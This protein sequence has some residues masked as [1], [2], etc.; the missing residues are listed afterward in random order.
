[1][2]CI[3]ADLARPPFQE[4]AFDVVTSQFG[5][6]YAGVE[7]ITETAHLVAPGGIFAAVLHLRDGGIFR[8]CTI[9]LEAIDGFRDCGL[10][11]CFEE[12]Y[13]TALAVHQRRAE[14][15]D[16]ERA[17]RRFAEAV[18]AAED[19]LRRRGRGVATGTLYRI[20]CDIGHMYQRLG[21]YEPQ[22]L[23]EWIDVTAR[24]LDA[25]SGRMSSMLGAALDARQMKRVL[26]DLEKLGLGV[27]VR[28]ILKFGRRPVPCAWVIVAENPGRRGGEK[29]LSVAQFGTRV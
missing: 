20:Y 9:N 26:A 3:A 12:V 2:F 27:R 22:E 13:R 25:Y 21:A 17:D 7:A 10:L 6:E 1:M 29:L 15:A 24:E 5:V 23:F 8:E 18:K 16:Y 14:K 11:R 4:G 28:G 19:I